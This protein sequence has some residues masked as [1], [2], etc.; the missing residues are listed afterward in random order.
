MQNAVTESKPKVE[1]GSFY[2]RVA[3]LYNLTFKFNGYGRSLEQ[4]LRANPLPLTPGAKILDAGCGTGLLTLALL[5]VI[6][7]PVHITAVDLS[8]TSIATARRAVREETGRTQAVAF[9]QAN[10]LQLPFRDNS[11]EVIVTSGVLEYVSLRE[12][13]GELARVL[14]PGGH[15]LHLPVYPSLASRF[16][17][18]L[19][20]FKTHP[21]D[22]VEANTSRY[23]NIISRHR[24]PRFHVIGWTK[25]AVVSQKV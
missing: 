14:A 10:V 11:F 25:S 18:L 8:A 20:H 7:M 21:P 15:L 12:G 6:D 3:S 9:S 23:F 2:D 4:Y 16:L 13:F 22:E 5:K 24:F 19:F 17:E 1:A